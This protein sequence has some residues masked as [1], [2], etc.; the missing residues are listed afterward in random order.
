MIQ[1]EWL[2]PLEGDPP[3]LLLA[4]SLI[5]QGLGVLYIIEHIIGRITR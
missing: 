3:W 2:E 5:L 4:A 1:E